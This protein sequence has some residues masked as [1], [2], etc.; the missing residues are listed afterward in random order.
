[1]ASSR[2]PEPTP[3]PYGDGVMLCVSCAMMAALVVTILVLCLW[4]TG[5]RAQTPNPNSANLLLSDCRDHSNPRVPGNYG[6]GICIGI[7]GNMFY[8]AESHFRFCT[9]P[10]VTAGQAL[11]VVIAYVD[12]RPTRHHEDFRNLALEALRVSWPCRQTGG[13]A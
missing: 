10:G 3:E 12:R 1:M 11:R 9:P 7:V 4:A 13:P 5:A 2:L 8:F 6:Q